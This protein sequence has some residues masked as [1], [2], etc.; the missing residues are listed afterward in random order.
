MIQRFSLVLMDKIFK[1]DK[2]VVQSI[3]RSVFS[4]TY[5]T[6]KATHIINSEYYIIPQVIFYLLWWK[7]IHSIKFIAFHI[8]HPLR[9]DL[10]VVFTFSF[11]I[12]I[13]HSISPIVS[14]FDIFLVK[15]HPSVSYQKWLA[16][17]CPLEIMNWWHVSPYSFV[18]VD[19]VNK[20]LL[21]SI[22]KE[23][24]IFL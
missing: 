24:V 11:I 9:I 15:I 19:I 8:N 17:K 1:S 16:C 21:L 23:R 3:P 10:N 7:V 20:I 14:W 18:S 5:S 22:E 4:L 12:R 13:V 6:K 2:V